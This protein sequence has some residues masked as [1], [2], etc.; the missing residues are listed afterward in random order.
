[1]LSRLGCPQWRAERVHLDRT[2][3]LTAHGRRSVTSLFPS[4]R[5]AACVRSQCATAWTGAEGG[6]SAYMANRYTQPLTAEY[7]EAVRA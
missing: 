4:S 1:M 3:A 7:G 6:R 5:R 2:A